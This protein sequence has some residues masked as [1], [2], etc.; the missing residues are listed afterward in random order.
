MRGIAVKLIGNVFWFIF[1][2]LWLGLGWS[3]A[4]IIWCVTIIGIPWGVQ[5]FKFARLAFAPFGKTVNYG[6]GLGSFLLN[7]LWIIL[8]GVP[9]CIEAAVIGAVLCVTI[10]GI[11]LGRQCF[12]FA[13]LALM[14]FGSTVDKA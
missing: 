11:P 3:I 2:G 10:I 6:G 5:C 7:L 14:P 9:L 12:K 4:G 1:A 13:R 8:S